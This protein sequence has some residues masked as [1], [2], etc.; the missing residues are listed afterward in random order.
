[1]RGTGPA[2]IDGDRPFRALLPT[3]RGLDTIC[4]DERT[5][6]GAKMFPVASGTEGWTEGG[7]IGE[8]AA[9]WNGEEIWTGVL[10]VGVEKNK[11]LCEVFRDR[12]GYAWLCNKSPPNFA[13]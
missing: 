8:E 11:Q 1:M 2:E 12:I 3:L 4:R 5:R 6:L 9:A 10:A 7:E 13:A